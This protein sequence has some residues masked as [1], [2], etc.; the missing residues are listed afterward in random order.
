MLGYYKDPKKTAEVMTGDYFHT[1]DKGTI[2]DEG[3]LKIT[4]RKKEIFK[5][6]GGKYIS[7]VLLENELK[8]SQFIEQLIVVGDGQKMACAII[9]PNFDFLQ[10]CCKH[11]DINY[12]NCNEDLIKNQKVIDRIQEEINEKNKKFGKWETI[13]LFELTSDV[14]SVDNNLLTPTFKIKRSE[15]RDKYND[16]YDKMYQN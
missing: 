10:A 2:D 7:P 15:I 4:G 1:G 16:L 12:G 9:Q 13:K 3:F 11:K 6:S 14:W 5:T 8:Q